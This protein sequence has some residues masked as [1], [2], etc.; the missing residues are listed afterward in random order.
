MKKVFIFRL[1]S[2]CGEPTD[3][4]EPCDLLGFNDFPE[5]NFHGELSIEGTEKLRQHLIDSLRKHDKNDE[6]NMVE[7]NTRVLEVDIKFSPR[8]IDILKNGH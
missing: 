7:L 8:G 2:T 1:C 4:I 6:A 5:T 3:I